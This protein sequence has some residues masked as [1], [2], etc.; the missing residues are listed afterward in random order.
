MNVCNKCGEL[1]RG[2][3]CSHCGGRLWRVVVPTTLAAI[4]IVAMTG[5]V[6]SVAVYGAPAI[7]EDGDGYYDGEDCDDQDADIYPGAPETPGDGV[8][9]DCDGEDPATDT[10]DTGE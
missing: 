1:S 7:D 10:S 6:K 5:C 2:T 3:T 8:D 4:G 9:S